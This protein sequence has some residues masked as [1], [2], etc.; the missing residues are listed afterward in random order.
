MKKLIY[1]SLIFVILIACEKER[2]E[3]KVKY[4]I[5]N[6]YSAVDVTYKN[7][8][9]QIVTETVD[10]ESNE[11]IWNYTYTDKRGEIV[12]ISSRYTD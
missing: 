7:C 3:V 10:F 9:G 6:A 8:D 12:Y 1:I 5:S 4:E 11:D 2:Q